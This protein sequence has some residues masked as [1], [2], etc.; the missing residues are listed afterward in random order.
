MIS[1]AHIHPMLVHFPIVF[2]L[3]LA[4]FDAAAVVTGRPVTGRGVAGGISTVLA[5]LAG[6]SAVLAMIFGDMAL[7]A[8]EAGGFSSEIAEIHEGLGSTTAIVF[9][10]WAVLRLILWWR[11]RPMSMAV[12]AGIAVLEVAGAGLMLATAYYGGQLVYDLGVN[13]ARAVGG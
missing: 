13:V 4:V 8:A 5:V 3:T 9:A 2:I 7:E 12:N 6:G 1:L 10:V 11:N